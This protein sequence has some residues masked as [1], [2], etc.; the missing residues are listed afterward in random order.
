MLLGYYFRQA[1]DTV[2]KYNTKN[3]LIA[4]NIS[5][6]IL[7]YYGGSDK[8]CRLAEGNYDKDNNACGTFTI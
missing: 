4:L 2:C 1:G 5:L 3:M 7:Y 8:S 6:D